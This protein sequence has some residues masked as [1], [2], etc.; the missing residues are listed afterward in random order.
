MINNIYENYPQVLI[1]NIKQIDET[2]TNEFDLL[3]TFKILSMILGKDFTT[4]GDIIW[5]GSDLTLT[6]GINTKYANGVYQF[7][8][9]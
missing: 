4:T 5:D 3:N 7:I 6:E 9:R 2:S 1:C 8:L